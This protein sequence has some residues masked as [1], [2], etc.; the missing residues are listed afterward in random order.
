MSAYSDGSLAHR[1]GEGADE[2]ERVVVNDWVSVMCDA[3][4]GGRGAQA[5]GEGRPQA[6]KLTFG[7]GP[8]VTV[9]RCKGQLELH[10]RSM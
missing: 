3:S 7:V 8:N 4:Q 2:V 5:R 1:T 10:S 9:S 6:R